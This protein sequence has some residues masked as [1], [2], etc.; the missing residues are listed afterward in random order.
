MVVG[1][2]LTVESRRGRVGHDPERG[3][4]RRNIS[5]LAFRVSYFGVWVRWSAGCGFRV[6]SHLVEVDDQDGVR[7]SG[8]GFLISGFECE[9]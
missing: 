9:D 3:R 7:V 6:Q 4:I 5:D 8:F 1:S 2:W